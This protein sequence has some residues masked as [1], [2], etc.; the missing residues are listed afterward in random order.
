VAGKKQEYTAF[1]RA[2]MKSGALAG[3]QSLHVVTTRHTEFIGEAIAAAL[4]NTRLR[5]TR[6]SGMPDSFDHSLY[7]IVAPQMFKT[8]PPPERRILFQ[9]EHVRASD[10][11]D[12][13]CVAR[14]AESL[15]VLDYSRKNIAALVGL[16]LQYQRLCCLPIRP[17]PRPGA[18]AAERDI[19]VLFYGAIASPRRAAYLRALGER[20]NLRVESDTFGPALRDLLDR[21]KVVANIH[22]YENALLETTRISEALS[23]GA[24]VVSEEAADQADGGDF[25]ALVDFVPE[26]ELDTFVQRVEAALAG[27]TAP[28]TLPG[29]DRFAGTA[30]HLLRALHGLG[31]LSLDEV[32]AAT[33]H[34]P[35]PSDRMILAL[36]EQTERYDYGMACRLPGAVPFHGL[37]H[38]DGWKGC[39]ASYKFLATHALAR[40]LPRLTIYEEYATFAPGSDARLAGI[41][42]Y[43]ATRGNGWDVFSGLLSD[44]GGDTAIRKVTVVNGEE[45][46]ELDSVIGMVF[47][48]CNRSALEMLAA[49]G[50]SGDDTMKHTID[51]Y[52]EKL[53]PHTITV[54]PPPVGHA[55]ALSSSLWPVNNALATPMI[56]SSIARLAEKREAFLADQ[57]QPAVRTA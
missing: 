8:L 41:E 57:D 25:T 2:R 20:V 31:I 54:W 39:A 42:R 28:A 33:A 13:A 16:G 35:M 37:R 32:Q 4:H 18:P 55:E 9:M 12:A 27:W 46:I 6:A 15:A 52:M 40:G 24:H 14:M 56:E 34:M 51:R 10:R 38:I 22:F 49:F 1:L 48:I 5:V 47:G 44:L 29:E 43:L 19:D 17:L 3:A 7:L 21:T 53:R 45:F 36:P 23:H 30:F 50:F 11:V 26:G